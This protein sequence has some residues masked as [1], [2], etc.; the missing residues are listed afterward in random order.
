VFYDG[1]CEKQFRTLNIHEEETIF[2]EIYLNSQ[3]YATGSVLKDDN[4]GFST[5]EKD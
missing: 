5:S 3:M 4:L 1:I 2:E